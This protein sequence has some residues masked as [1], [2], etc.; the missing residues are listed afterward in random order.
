MMYFTIKVIFLVSV[1]ANLLR[2]TTTNHQEMIESPGDSATVVTFEFTAQGRQC[3]L[4]EGAGGGSL[5]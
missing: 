5:G 4:F 1:Y 3:F 2:T